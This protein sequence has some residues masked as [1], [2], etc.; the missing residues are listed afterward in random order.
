MS[1][2]TSLVIQLLRL[3]VHWRGHG[4]DPSGTKIQVQSGM[5]H[6]RPKSVKLFLIE[7]IILKKVRNIALPHWLSKCESVVKMQT[8]RSELRVTELEIL[9]VEPSSL[10]FKS[11]L[12]DSD[13]HWS[14]RTTA[15]DNEW[16]RVIG[17]CIF[18]M[19][20]KVHCRKHWHGGL[21][22]TLKSVSDFLNGKILFFY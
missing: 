14:L 6:P 19:L 10:W 2:R 22:S 13:G 20:S 7:M 17:I 1:S 12:G 3:H 9:K 21:E 4:F 16:G 11:T 18:N 5:P 15:L 8:L